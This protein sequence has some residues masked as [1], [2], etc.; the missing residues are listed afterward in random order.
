M[1][2]VDHRNVAAET[3]LETLPEK[4]TF[5]KSAAAGCDEALDCV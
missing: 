4:R 3:S 5:R 1:L 2:V